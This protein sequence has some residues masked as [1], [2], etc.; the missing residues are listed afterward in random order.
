VPDWLLSVGSFGP[1]P[2]FAVAVAL[3]FR[4]KGLVLGAAAGLALR[5]ASLRPT[6]I[7]AA[8]AVYTALAASTIVVPVVATLLAPQRVEPQLVTAQA[9]LSKNGAILAALILFMVGVVILGDGIAEL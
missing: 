1:L 7:A 6:E 8:I 5:D 9:W 4:P 2:S 3:N